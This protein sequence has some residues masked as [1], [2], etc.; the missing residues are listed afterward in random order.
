M[1]AEREALGRTEA[2]SAETVLK[3]GVIEVVVFVKKF[4]IKNESDGIDFGLESI[5]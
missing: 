4:Y 1:F 5:L 2:N 3:F